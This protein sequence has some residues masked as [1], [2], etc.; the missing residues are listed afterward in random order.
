MDISDLRQNHPDH[1]AKAAAIRV[2][3]MDAV[4]AANSGHPG[5]PMGMAD[6][7]T[8]LFEKHLK[9]DASAPDWAD[10]DRFILSAGHGSMLL[11]SL[12]HLTGYED[13]T[14]EQIRNFRQLGAIT[15]GHPEYGHAKGIETTTGPLGQGIAT[16]VGFAMAE[17]SMA[18]RFGKKVVDHHTYV[19]AGDGCLMEGISHEAIGLAGKQK[20]GKLIVLWDDNGISIDGKVDLSDVTDQMTRFEAAGWSVFSCDG[21]DPVAIDRAIAQAKQSPLPSM[22]AC[23]TH[24]GFGSPAKQDTSKAHGSP[25]GPDEIAK[26]REIYGWPHPAFEIPADIKSAWEAIGAHGAETRKAWEEAKATLS[27]ARQAEFDRVMSGAAPKRLSAAIKAFKKQVSADA[28]KVA[29]RKSSEMAL[30]VINKIAPETIGGSA[31]LTGSNNTLTEGL[32]TFDADNRKGRYVY[33]GIREHGMAAAMNGLSL[34]GGVKAYGGTFMCFTDYARGA[35]RLSALMGVP[36]TYVMTHDS[37]GL[38]EDGPTHQPVEHLAINRATPNTNLF[39]P[40]DTIETAEAWELAITSESTPSVLAL[41]RQGLPT[42]RTKHTTKNLTAQGAYVLAEADAKRR[43][44]LMATGSEVEI[45]MKAKE[46]LEAKGIGTRVVSMPCWELFAAQ[47]EKYRRRV[48]PAGPVRVAVEAGARMGWDQWLC[49]ER[50][51]AKKA[52][53][54]GMD[55]FGASGPID[56]LYEHFGITPEAVAAKVEALL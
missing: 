30:E 19:I 1:W 33:Y 15:A 14:I 46:I 54:V 34:H 32:G 18:A 44:I 42:L 39:R 29:T 26:V 8:V 28:P 40:C 51:S 47:D 5:M 12:L 24:I 16:A 56:D 35:M 13:M 55:G 50:G 23:K 48:L 38:G 36:V 21:H 10:R 7:A 27:G 9:F 41:T 49:G 6:V 37:I 17:Q 4:Q 52:D 20:L 2:L 3:S 11:Y 31:D 43:A 22:I 53:F 45:A 25:L